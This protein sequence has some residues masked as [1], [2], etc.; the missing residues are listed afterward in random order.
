MAPKPCKT[1]SEACL[2]GWLSKNR[3]CG[4][5]AYGLDCDA[6][7]TRGYLSGGRKAVGT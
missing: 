7:L 6:G 3:R 2:P 4:V 1:C 5:L